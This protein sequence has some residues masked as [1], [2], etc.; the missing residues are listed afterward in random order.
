MSKEINAISTNFRIRN[1]KKQQLP[2]EPL[3]FSRC[4]DDNEIIEDLVENSR[5]KIRKDYVE[6]RSNDDY[7][8]ENA[9]FDVNILS[10][11]LVNCREG[12]IYNDELTK[13]LNIGTIFSKEEIEEMSDIE[14]KKISILLARERG[15]LRKNPN[16]YSQ[17]L[18]ELTEEGLEMVKL[19]SVRFREAFNSR[20]KRKFISNSFKVL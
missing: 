11:N 12:V 16:F 6:M 19:V 1:G 17:P 7:D 14:A 9:R 10:S 13:I 2:G 18:C 3:G 4:I 8:N 15:K 20:E 5:W